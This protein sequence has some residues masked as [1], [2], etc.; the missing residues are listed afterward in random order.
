MYHH[1]GGF[2][3]D[4]VFHQ[5]IDLW[6]GNLRKT[7]NVMKRKDTGAQIESKLTYRFMEIK[8]VGK[9]AF[10]VDRRDYFRYGQGKKRVE[11][12]IS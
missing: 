5:Q 3:T 12:I 4:D 1:L 2:L 10:Q 11:D 9:N 8:K 6:G 7:D